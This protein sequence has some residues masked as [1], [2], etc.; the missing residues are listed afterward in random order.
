MDSN[1]IEWN[2]RYV[3]YAATMGR[4]PE[5]QLVADREVWPGGCMVGFMLW[6][7]ACKQAFHKL[8]PDAFLG[9]SYDQLY[10]QDA[11]ADYLQSLALESRRLDT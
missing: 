9:N 3:A 2:P 1:Q 6:I 8:R 7:S 4:T 10:D 11:F 5:A